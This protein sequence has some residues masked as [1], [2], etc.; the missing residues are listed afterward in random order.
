MA[1]S[2]QSLAEWIR[3][4]MNDL[5]KLRLDSDEIKKCTA[6]SLV[7]LSGGVHEKEVHS[8]RLGN[9]TTSPDDLARIFQHKAEGFSQE[10]PGVQLFMLLA[11]Y[12]NETTP[13][14][15]HPFRVQGE[16]AY[17]GLG[18]EAPT[19][20]GLTQQQMRHNESLV[21]GSFRQNAMTF[22][23][24]L[25]ITR[26][27]TM[28]ARTTRKENT[29]LVNMMKDL[30]MQNMQLQYSNQLQLKTR[31]D[32]SRL[33]GMAPALVNSIVGKEVFPTQTADSA[34]MEAIAKS[35]SPEQAQ[36][37]AAALPP[38]VMPHVMNRITEILKEEAKIVHAAGALQPNREGKT[39]IEVDAEE[40]DEKA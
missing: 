28:E 12:D 31:D 1:R 35:L 5:D 24:L 26:E 39:E 30:M 4:A 10:T 17:E 13:S 16:I 32:I 37:L 18:T 29:E 21:S 25:E 15:R 14:A 38:Q 7:H 3:E 19:A 27:N 8:V 36:K 2:K 9:K 33:L 34:I 23:V 22:E 40:E 20:T 6:F 11:F